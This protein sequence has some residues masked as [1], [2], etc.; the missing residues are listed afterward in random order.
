MNSNFNQL[1]MSIEEARRCLGIGRS[2]MYEAVRKKEIP[3]IRLGRRLL[4]PKHALQEMLNKSQD[5]SKFRDTD[6]GIK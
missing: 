6:G 4:I 5:N 1:T 3:S 2:L